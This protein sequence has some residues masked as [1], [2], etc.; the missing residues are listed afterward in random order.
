MHTYIPAGFIENTIAGVNN[1]LL[2]FF[3]TEQA[4]IIIPFFDIAILEFLR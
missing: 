1:T 2:N 4:Y 3:A